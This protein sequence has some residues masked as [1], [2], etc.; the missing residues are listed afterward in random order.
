VGWCKRLARS[1]R[2][3]LVSER[4]RP[5]I[6]ACPF[7]GY[8]GTTRGTRNER[9]PIQ[10]AELFNKCEVLAVAVGLD[11]FAEGKPV[12]RVS[13]KEYA[14]GDSRNVIFDTPS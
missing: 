8:F 14:L 3:N 6:A 12:T 2:R 1:S 7:R 10:A 5:G 13:F 9:R 11:S 4:I